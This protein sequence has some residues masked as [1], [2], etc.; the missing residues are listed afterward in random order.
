MACVNLCL[1]YQNNER[2]QTIYQ[3]QTALKDKTKECDL[4][5]LV[6]FKIDY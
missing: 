1:N 3:H 4:Q 5:S 2:L 6:C